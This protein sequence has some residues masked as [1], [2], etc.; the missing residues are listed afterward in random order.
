MKITDRSGV[1]LNDTWGVPPF[2]TPLR[3]A[4]T[5]R[6]SSRRRHV[7]FMLECQVAYIAGCL[8][9]LLSASRLR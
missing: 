9:E 6:V 8:R 2:P 5:D 3:L 7:I 1:K 4:C